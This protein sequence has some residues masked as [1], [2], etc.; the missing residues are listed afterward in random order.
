[1]VKTLQGGG[2]GLF[3]SLFSSCPYLFFKSRRDIFS[4]YIIAYW[5]NF[6]VDNQTPASTL[7]FPYLNLCFSRVRKKVIA[8]TWN[9]KKNGSEHPS[10][11]LTSSGT[12]LLPRATV[13]MNNTQ[14]RSIRAPTYRKGPLEK[15]K[16]QLYPFFFFYYSYYTTLSIHTYISFLYG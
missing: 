1:M 6:A 14:P 5:P 8:T 13:R 10:I 15:K 16:L 11:L 7:F 9:R 2:G 4:G 12:D 3:G